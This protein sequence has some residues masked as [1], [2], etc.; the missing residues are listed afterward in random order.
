MNYFRTNTLTEQTLH[1]TIDSYH[2]PKYS[3]VSSSSQAKLSI[4]DAK[5]LELQANSKWPSLGSFKSECG[6]NEEFHLGYKSSS[7]LLA[8]LLA[9]SLGRLLG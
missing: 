7:G 2:S 8:C 5:S 4:P 3:Q 6:L 1:L 9:R